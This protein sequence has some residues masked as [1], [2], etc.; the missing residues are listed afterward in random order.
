MGGWGKEPDSF[1]FAPEDTILRFLLL[2][3]QSGFGQESP[4]KW[5]K[6][7]VPVFMLLFQK[8]IVG[9]TTH[10]FDVLRAHNVSN[11]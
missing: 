2:G 10:P 11:S 6:K 7:K 4:G 5:G 3:G 9:N 1:K 8:L